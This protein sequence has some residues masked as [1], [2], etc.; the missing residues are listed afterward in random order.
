MNRII[1]GDKMK[2]SI[3]IILPI[4]TV[5]ASTTNIKKE[6]VPTVPVAASTIV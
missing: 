3:I 1:K 6:V 4:L 2:W 5:M